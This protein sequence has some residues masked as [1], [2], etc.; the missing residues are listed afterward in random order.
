MKKVS[1]TV[2]LTALLLVGGG[3]AAHAA[4]SGDWPD[5]T[6]TARSGDWPDSTGSKA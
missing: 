1:A 3:T 5:R 6:T 2:L 4:K